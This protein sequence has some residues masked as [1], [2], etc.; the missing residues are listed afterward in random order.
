MSVEFCFFLCLLRCSG[1]C[2]YGCVVVRGTTRGGGVLGA[3]HLPQGR[4]EGSGMCTD[5]QQ[6]PLDPPSTQSSASQT[7]AVAWYAHVEHVDVASL[8]DGSATSTCPAC[9]FQITA[10]GLACMCC[11]WGQSRKQHCVCVGCLCIQML[12]ASK[13]TILIIHQTG[14]RVGVLC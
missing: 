10:R 3:R 7:R 5:N 14:A 1:V 11:G 6:L 4:P 12:A 2:M 9:V 13:H 8:D